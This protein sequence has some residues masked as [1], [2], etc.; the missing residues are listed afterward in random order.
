MCLCLA[1]NLVDDMCMTM[2]SNT[3]YA[4]AGH[5]IVNGSYIDGTVKFLPTVVDGS[6]VIM[7]EVNILGLEGL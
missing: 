3:D 5:A 4:V 1:F 7:V 2:L 6:T